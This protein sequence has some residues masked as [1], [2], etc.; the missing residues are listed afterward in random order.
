MACEY[1]ARSNVQ[2]AAPLGAQPLRGTSGL[3]PA[4]RV[5]MGGTTQS[6]TIYGSWNN[7]W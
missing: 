6:T 3:Y 4:M 7:T 1:G 5:E 2:G